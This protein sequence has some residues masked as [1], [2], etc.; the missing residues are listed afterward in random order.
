MRWRSVLAA[1]SQP[2]S[3]PAIERIDQTVAAE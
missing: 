3:S 1:C 2:V